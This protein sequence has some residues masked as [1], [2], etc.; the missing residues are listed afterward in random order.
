MNV[1]KRI[2]GVHQNWKFYAQK[3]L[4]IKRQAA[5]SEKI[6]ANND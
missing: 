1:K 5:D 3:S 6:F 4:L 2:N